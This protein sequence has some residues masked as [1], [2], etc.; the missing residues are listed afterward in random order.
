M[1]KSTVTFGPQVRARRRNL[2]QAWNGVD[3][4]G[5]LEFSRGGDD[6]RQL[7]LSMRKISLDRLLRGRPEGTEQFAP[8]PNPIALPVG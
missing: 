6:L 3:G 2:G 8:L 5:R 7:P 4:S 1:G